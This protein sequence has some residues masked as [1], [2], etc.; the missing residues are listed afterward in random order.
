[1]PAMKTSYAMTHFPKK[2]L[3][4][5]PAAPKCLSKAE[6]PRNLNFDTREQAKKKIPLPS[7]I[8]RDDKADVRHVC[9]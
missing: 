4:S 8:G 7:K 9:V 1:M 6:R 3:Q 2:L 5:S